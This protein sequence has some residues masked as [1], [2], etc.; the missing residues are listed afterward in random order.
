MPL[1]NTLYRKMNAKQLLLLFIVVMSSMLLATGFAVLHFFS[2]PA[3]ERFQHKTAEMEV[4]AVTSYFEKYLSEEIEI[5]EQIAESSIST[6]IVMGSLVSSSSISDYFDGSA[7][8]STRPHI[9]Y[10]DIASD[11]VFSDYS[12]PLSAIQPDI[13]QV[14]NEK[15]DV[16]V[17]FHLEQ[18]KL[19]LFT[20]VPIAYGGYVEGVLVTRRLFDESIELSFIVDRH[21]RALSVIPINRNDVSASADMSV[22]SV[23]NINIREGISLKYFI[24]KESLAEQSKTLINSMGIALL[25]AIAICFLGVYYFGD[26]LLVQPFADLE[27]SESALS[28]KTEALIHSERE[29]KKLANVARFTKDTIVITDELGIIVWV[30]DSFEQLTGYLFDEVIGQ[31]PGDLLQ[32]E[33]TDPFTIQLIAKALKERRSVRADLINYDRAGQEYWI[34]LDIA[35]VYGDDGTLTGFI[36]VERDITK[37][38][39]DQQ[40]MLEALDRAK[41]ADRVKSQFLA[42]ISH[43]IRTPM[44]G[45]LGTVQLLNDTALDNYQEE[46][47]ENLSDSANYM[48]SLLNDVLDYS[49]IAAGKLDF[50]IEE[51]KVADIASYI[52]FNLSSQCEKKGLGYYVDNQIPED[53]LILTDKVRVNQILLNLA[54][55]AVKFTSKGKVTVTLA[56]APVDKNVSSDN[57]DQRLLLRVEDTGI[58]ISDEN[59]KAIFQQFQQIDDRATREYRGLGLGLTIIKMICD[60][61]EGRIHVESELGKGSIFTVE[62]DVSVVNNGACAVVEDLPAYEGQGRHILIVDDDRVNGFVLAMMLKKRGFVTTIAMDGFQALEKIEDKPY[63]L[64]IMDNNMPK[65]DGV[66]ATRRIR[67]LESPISDVLIFGFTADA[68]TDTTINMMEA[69]CQDVLIKP[70]KEERLDQILHQFDHRLDVVASSTS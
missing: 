43:E 44:N 45:V 24:S 51:V 10:V 32:G 28:K 21:D 56:L 25:I 70:L 6:N 48:M 29:Q 54:N 50:F 18:D 53:I 62:L 13:D 23:E 22:W 26:L 19:Y 12:L 36:S 16:K 69:G 65:M 57:E 63:S 20:I 64:V 17:S 68:H 30:N 58:G 35:P 66:E 38:K 9:A 60:K 1:D 14:L 7:V 42:S 3:I 55:N 47:T 15:S 46:L 37:Q 59:Q 41:E 34:D 33:K 11:I 39:A 67:A 5:A 4:K 27:K 8:L 52:Q 49:K 2:Q 40:A 31:R 61:L